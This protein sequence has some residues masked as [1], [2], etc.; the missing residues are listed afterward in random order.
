MKNKI[1]TILMFVFLFT[2]TLASCE[3][4]DK[5][6]T[7]KIDA[8]NGTAVQEIKVIDGQLV[9]KP[10]DPS[11]EGFIFEGWF[12]D[13]NSDEEY[14]FASP[15]KDDLVIYAK[16]LDS[17]TTYTV[18]FETNGGSEIVSKQVRI[19]GTLGSVEEPKKSC[20]VFDQWYTDEELKHPFNLS[21]P[22]DE[23]LVLYAGYK[24][25]FVL[26]I[27][28]NTNYAEYLQ[29]I[30]EQQN[31][32]L[33]YYVRDNMYMVG[34]LNAWKA[35]PQIELGYY[36]EENDDYI[37]VEVSWK[38]T[39]ELKENGVLVEDNDLYV[40]SFNEETCEILFNDAAVD[41]EFTVSL[42]PYGLTNRQKENLA[43]YVI[44]F[45]VKVVDAYN[46]YSVYELAYLEN[47]TEAQNGN[48]GS[49]QLLNNAFWTAFKEE[50][51]LLL[52][53]NP[54]KFVLHTNLTINETTIPS[55]YFY[56]DET[57]SKLDSDYSRTFGSLIDD[58]E[59]FFRITAQDEEF[60]FYGNY[61][62]IDCSTLREV[63][64]EWNEITPEGEVISHAT[65][66]RFEGEGSVEMVNLSITGNAP[67]VE[68]TIKAG[69]IIFT[70]VEGPE[71]LFD[72]MLC[73]DFF[74]T[75]MP[76]R[77]HKEMVID[78]AKVINAYNSFLYNWGS[79]YLIVKNSLF[80]S[81]GGPVLIQDCVDYG[82]EN[83]SNGKTTFID[84]EFDSFVTGQESWF[85][86]FNATLLVGQIKALDQIFNAYGKSF[87][88]TDVDHNTYFNLI[89]VNK[90]GEA[91]GITSSPI[92][93]STLINDT[94]AFDF[95]ETNP[96]FKALFQQ[97]SALGAPVFQGN[98][99][100]LTEG[101]AYFDGQYL[102]DVQQQII[103]DP[104]NPLFTSQ[105]I[106]LYYGGMC[107]VFELF[108]MGEAY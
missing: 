66:F 93:G 15:V 22:I 76:N 104:N 33:Q 12:L 103:M 53:Y 81:S 96:Y 21:T 35:N 38:Y 3:L 108:N 99:S 90:S 97:A 52:N 26:G 14:D 17:S 65:L 34:T 5:T 71:A 19:G 68:N 72:N 48:C 107:M 46:I 18:S 31:E 83:Q 23:D 51:D 91:Q 86:S 69:G 40:A 45:N 94:S 41:H 16:W 87:L 47:R 43:R 106:A 54:S 64:R 4:G 11:R 9:A 77:H 50:H 24:Q 10:A 1:I 105:Y 6:H 56:S 57:I 100:T 44:S 42:T 27:S 95:G 60:K 37:E 78:H 59:I 82:S 63:Q 39:L 32:D 92:E 29:N 70:K 73:F 85:V 102:R 2:L 84:C 49:I 67:R 79:E 62:N 61:F 74:I 58:S 36:D 98:N 28:Q 7:V 25:V 89:V 8:A 20:V 30:K 88:K 55:G 101:Y 75:F 80:K 13:L